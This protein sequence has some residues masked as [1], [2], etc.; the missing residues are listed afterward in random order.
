[1]IQD[2][3]KAGPGA[4]AGLQAG[5]IVTERDGKPVEDMVS[6]RNGIARSKPGTPAKL[7]VW[8]DGKHRKLTVKL[9]ELPGESGA[10]K[11]GGDGGEL[12]DVSELGLGLADVTPML[13]R[14]FEL[15]DDTGAVVLEVRPGSAASEAGLR[16]GDLIERV[17]GKAVA[18]AAEANGAIAAADLSVGVRLR[19]EREGR[20]LFVMLHKR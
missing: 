19:V 13:K 10:P 17:A 7:T 3:G 1:M 15:E 2:V 11:G 16:P 18:S 14:R 6:F 20:G 9:G 4:Q 12:S 5:D 8:R